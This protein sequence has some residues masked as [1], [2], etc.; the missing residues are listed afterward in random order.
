MTESNKKNMKWKDRLLSSSLPLEYEIGKILTEKNYIIDF[1]YSYKRHDNQLEKEFSIDLKAN[2]FYPIGKYKRKFIITDLLIEC[3]YRNPN[4][5]WLFLNDFNNKE[6]SN[7]THKGVIKF[8]DEFSLFHSINNRTFFPT[9]DLCLKGVEINTN[10]GEVHD[11]GIIHG[12]NQLVYC[13]PQIIL[14]YIKSTF[15]DHLSDVDPYI[16]C[17]ILVTTADL[18]IINEDFSILNVHQ[19]D[20]LDSISREVPYIRLYSDVYPSFQ[21]H[22]ENLFDNLPSNTEEEERLKSLYN[23]RE[24]KGNILDKPGY[25]KFYN[26][27]FELISQ[28]RNGIANDIF[29][30]TL[31]C[32][33]NHFPKLLTEIEQG[34]DSI[35][36]GI[37]IIKES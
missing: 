36:N 13:M 37:T 35:S 31:I 29:R 22:C 16:L 17:P 9:A 6:Y 33:H 25:D 11:K 19:T 8:F 24:Y 28:L 30:E 21:D 26:N 1:D 27:T 10:N 5:S 18:R 2:N 20:S 34:I 23:L 7:F 14:S 12:I 32:N 3:K 4:I 15:S